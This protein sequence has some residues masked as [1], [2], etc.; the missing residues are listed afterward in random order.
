MY[1]LVP[2]P[3]RLCDC[4]VLLLTAWPTWLPPRPRW[5]RRSSRCQLPALTS[6]IEIRELSSS[7]GSSNDDKPRTFS[8][9]SNF[10]ASA[11]ASAF[12]RSAAASAGVMDLV[13]APVC[14]KMA[15]LG[16]LTRLL[17]GTCTAA[18]LASPSTCFLATLAS[19]TA[20]PK[21]DVRPTEFQMF[22]CAP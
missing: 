3:L 14:T 11:P 8:S 21:T 15:A 18:P 20:P 19:V 17:H 16:A 7:T 1:F 2:S 22:R 9:A 6:N 10:S 12:C 4:L 5:P 13:L